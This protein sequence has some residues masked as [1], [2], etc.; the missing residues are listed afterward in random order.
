M[1]LFG[2]STQYIPHDSISIGQNQLRV[3]TM[4]VNKLLVKPELTRIKGHS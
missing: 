2:I 1:K 4:Q 3:L